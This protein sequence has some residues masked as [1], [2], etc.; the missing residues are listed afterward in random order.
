MACSPPLH[1]EDDSVSAAGKQTNKQSILLR[2]GRSHDCRAL[3]LSVVDNDAGR[4]EKM[5][6]VRKDTSYLT[7]QEP[8]R[9]P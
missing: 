9:G 3:R 2:Y 6:D 1:H 8:A 4:T 7:A 5:S